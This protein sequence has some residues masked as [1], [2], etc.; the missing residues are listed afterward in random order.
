MGKVIKLIWNL[1]NKNRPRASA[2]LYFLVLIIFAYIYLKCYESNNTSFVFAKEIHESKLYDRKEKNN[3]EINKLQNLYNILDSVYYIVS[4]NKKAPDS[5]FRQTFG[6]A[7]VYG[8]KVNN[9]S[10]SFDISEINYIRKDDTP[11]HII[12]VWGDSLDFT[13]HV[14]YKIISFPY[15]SL[16]VI[17]NLIDIE[18]KNIEMEITSL[19]QTSDIADWGFI[20]FLYFSTMTQTTIGYGDILPNSSCIRL[21][22][23]IQSFLSVFCTV[24]FVIGSF[25]KIE[26]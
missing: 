21:L 6:P 26:K 8:Y 4:V 14:K 2:I 11:L 20:D 10:I 9:I 25:Q 23:T 19:V 15:D 1:M 3:Q 7:Q 5:S 13:R 18:K 24:F 16:S 17:I 12:E 22:V